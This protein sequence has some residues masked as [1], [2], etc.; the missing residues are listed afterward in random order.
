[1]NDFPAQGGAFVAGGSGG[2]GRA[3]CR[4]LAE[5]GC[6][7]ALT[8]HNGRERAEATAELVRAAGRKAVVLQIDLR[9]E[10]AVARAVDETALDF[11]ALHTAIYAAGPYI[12]MR[13]ISRIEPALFRDTMEQDAFG[14]FNLI[15]AA[16]P[17]L[18]SAKG[19]FVALATPALRRY[20]VKDVLSVA[21]KAAIEALIRG[22]AAEEG[23]FGVRAN[24]VGVGVI[25]DG[26]YHALMETGDFDQRFLDASRQNMALRRLGTADEIAEAVVFLASARARWITGQT[27]MV[28]GG[29]AL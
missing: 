16:L 12:H 29:Y 3:I 21:P 27:L 19:A 1:M 28:D 6:D 11:G 5:T 23:R 7:V 10:K 9:D 22:V 15:H 18:R 17:H 20:A 8:Y 2:I 4:M 24:G 14:C 25:E 26:M 13:H